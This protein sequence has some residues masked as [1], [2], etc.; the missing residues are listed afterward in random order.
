VNI[1][2]RLGDKGLYITDCIDQEHLKHLSDIRD[3]LPKKEDMHFY[4]SVLNRA[5]DKDL[6]EYLDTIFRNAILEYLNESQKDI[7]DYIASLA[8][9]INSWKTGITLYEHRDS[10]QYND[11]KQSAG[12][13]PSINV[14]AYLTDDYKDGEIFF[15]EVGV[16]IRPKSGSVVIFDSDLMH[17]VNAVTSG[18]RRTL[19]SNLYSIHSEDIEEFKA[20]GFRYL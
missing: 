14:L 11:L 6:C 5:V 2:S 10:T 9:R 19:S 20:K 12:P 8:Y 18:D 17:G 1:E 16:S 13:R 3:I 4:M 7:N 15:S